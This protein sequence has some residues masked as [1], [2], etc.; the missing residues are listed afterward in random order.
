MIVKVKDN[1]AGKIT[2]RPVAEALH[3]RFVEPSP[4]LAA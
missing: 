4:A 1:H 3:H 2:N